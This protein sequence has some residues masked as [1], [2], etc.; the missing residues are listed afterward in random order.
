MKYCFII[1][2]HAGKGKFVAEL[3]QDI[4]FACDK[5]EKSYDIFISNS[6]DDTK[7]YIEDASS[8][9]DEG[10][11]FF[12]C[13]GDGTLCETILS[14]MSLDEEKRKNVCVGIVPKGTGND[15]VSNFENKELFCNIEAQIAGETHD[16]DLLKCNELYSVNMIN[17]GFD[18]HVVC[19]KEEIGKKKFVP[20][21]LAYIFSLI[22]TLIKKPT[23]S[24][25]RCDDGNESDKKTLL[26]TTLANG[27]FC[28]GGFYSNPKASLF[29]GKIDCIEANNMS[30]R[31]FVSLVGD[32]KS[33]KHLCEKFNGIIENF[34]TESTD[35][36]F[37]EETP[38]SVDGEIIRTKELHIRVARRALSVLI[39]R[40]VKPKVLAEVDDDA[41][42]SVGHAR[43]V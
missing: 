13:G 1:N 40:G 9:S 32:Y 42:D 11:V 26:L 34:K 8:D 35:L 7:K 17:I 18:C 10:I 4:I 39:P 12:A 23:V 21:K 15:F 3:E 24:L 2:P 20:R 5:A 29:D 19:K 36:Y 27:G 30:R 38:V 33:G 6:I 37:D 28:G 22:I 16:I 31:K 41:F 14:V 43:T 25:K